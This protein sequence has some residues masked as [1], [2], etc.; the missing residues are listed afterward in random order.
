MTKHKLN[1][2]PA[3]L[4]DVS[5]PQGTGSTLRI[6]FDEYLAMDGAF[7]NYDNPEPEM[8]AIAQKLINAVLKDVVQA[9]DG[10]GGD[11]TDF[12]AWIRQQIKE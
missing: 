7:K 8:E 5:V 9:S 10:F 4:L 1:L 6:L 3:A 12:G 2:T 11:A